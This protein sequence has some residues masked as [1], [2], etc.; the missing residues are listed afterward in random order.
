MWS[1]RRE[2]RNDFESVLRRV[3]E[4]GYLGVEVASLHEMEPARFGE[5]TDELGLERIAIHVE[6]DA[7]TTM[8]EAEALGISAIVNGFYEWESLADLRRQIGDLNGAV[9]VAEA[10]GMQLG[11]HNHHH[12]IAGQ[13]DGRRVYD[14]LL[15]ELDPR[16]F[17]ELDAYWVAV[18]DADPAELLRSLGDR[19]RILHV[20]DGAARDADEPNTAVGAG[21]LDV[22]AIV[23]ACPAPTWHVVELDACAGDM[24]EAVEESYRYLVNNG[25]SRGRS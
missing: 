1:L 6:E 8:D 2:A 12:E 4:I 11:Y 21:T 9:E 10:R 19:T 23:A 15:E 22:P 18:G 5:L 16:I 3:A 24:L 25:L 13:V 7:R 20:K 17:M 14:V